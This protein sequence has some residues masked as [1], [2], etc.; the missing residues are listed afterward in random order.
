MANKKTLT[1][2]SALERFLLSL[3]T[4]GSSANTLRSYRFKLGL[5]VHL[6]ETRCTDDGK[7]FGITVLKQVTTDHLRQV[8]YILQNEDVAH[9]KGRRREPG[10]LADTSVKNYVLVLK[11]FFSWC[12]R[13]GLITSNPADNR[14]TLPKTAKRVKQTFSAETIQLMLSVCDRSTDVGFRD[15]TMLLVLFDTGMRLSELA[16]LAVENVHADYVKVEGK[17]R[18]EREIGIHTATSMV[19]WKYIEMHRNPTND[20]EPYV[21]ISAYGTWLRGSG[22]HQV[23][24]RIQAKAGLDDIRAHAHLFRHTFAKFYMENGGDLF[25]LSREMGHSDVQTTKIY[26]ED[27]TSTNARKAHVRFSPVSL[28]EVKETRR[29]RKK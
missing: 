4:S 11:S 5:V 14:L 1:I 12:Y 2:S 29:R 13:E 16:S 7:R 25:N 17:G 9:F 20:N 3:S 6:I 27:F 26:L 24:K 21:F 28:I 18:Q 10:R 19:L 15:Y 22:V 23:I 8:I